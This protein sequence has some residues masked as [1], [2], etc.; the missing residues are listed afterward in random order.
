MSGTEGEKLLTFTPD[1]SYHAHL[2]PDLIMFPLGSDVHVTLVIV[3]DKGDLERQLS[4]S[5]SRSCI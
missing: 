1:S 5:H 4:P 2:C 3:T